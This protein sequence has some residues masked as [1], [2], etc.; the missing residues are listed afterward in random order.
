MDKRDEVRM[1]RRT[2]TTMPLR[3]TTYYYVTLKFE[4]GQRR[5]FRVKGNEY[6]LLV[7]GDEGILNYQ[8]D[9]FK[10]FHRV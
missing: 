1:R 7:V 3:S 5:G 6:G 8:G 4:P 10:G 2:S 9:W